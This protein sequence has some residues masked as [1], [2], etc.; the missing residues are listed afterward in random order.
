MSNAAAE[1]YGCVYPTDRGDYGCDEG[2][3]IC[4][5]V[6]KDRASK[7]H[8]TLQDPV[9]K[10]YTIL[11]NVIKRAD[12]SSPTRGNNEC[13]RHLSP[14]LAPL[15][16][17]TRRCNSRNLDLTSAPPLR[18]PALASSNVTSRS[19]AMIANQLHTNSLCTSKEEVKNAKIAQDSEDNKER[20]SPCLHQ[21]RSC[22]GPCSPPGSRR[23][24]ITRH[25]T[26]RTARRRRL[27]TAQITS[28]I[29]PGII[30]ARDCTHVAH[31]IGVVALFSTIKIVCFNDLRPPP[32]RSAPPP[33]PTFAP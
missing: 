5:T 30:P 25:L 28:G 22:L 13:R 7:A 15:S 9:A 27:E 32:S 4:S 10:T 33:R 18:S 24:H 1:Q 12:V 26:A 29:S 19:R 21:Q 17:H 20:R 6:R 11:Q 3:F 31:R 2:V 8:R 14:S 16:T 23:C